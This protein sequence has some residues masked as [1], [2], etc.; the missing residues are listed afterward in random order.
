MNELKSVKELKEKLMSMYSE[1]YYCCRD[2]KCKYFDECKNDIVEPCKYF[3]DKVRIGHNYGRD[4]AIPKIMFVGLEAKHPDYEN[5]V[6]EGI[7]D[8]YQKAT[9]SHFRGLRY[10]LSYLLAPF[11]EEEAPKNTKIDKRFDDERINVLTRFALSNIYKCAFGNYNQYRNLPHSHSM[12]KYCQRILFDEI[13]I[14]EPDIV[15]A[16]IVENKPDLFWKNILDKYSDEKENLICGD[17]KNNNTSVYKMRH[18][19]GK[20]FLFV[21]S[22]HGAWIPFASQKYLAVLNKVLDATLENYTSRQE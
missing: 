20:P 5:Q 10:V 9:N 17:G 11:F 7:M 16:Q 22:Y 3:S 6:V 21:W 1:K 8:I 13:D 15:V 12:K 18:K 14:L 4:I 19:N 2:G